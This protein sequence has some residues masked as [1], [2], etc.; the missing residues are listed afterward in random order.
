MC[1]RMLSI[2]TS[3]HDM[4]LWWQ[5][6]RDIVPPRDLIMGKEHLR[7]ALTAL[8]QL[9]QANLTARCHAEEVAQQQ[10]PP[11]DEQSVSRCQGLSADAAQQ[12]PRRALQSRSAEALHAAQQQGV[13]L[14][15][16]AHAHEDAWTPVS[17]SWRE[18]VEFMR[19]RHGCADGGGGSQRAIMHGP[20]TSSALEATLLQ[21]VGGMPAAPWPQRRA[22]HP[23]AAA[24]SLW[25]KTA[26][27]GQQS[28]GK[29]LAERVMHGHVRSREL[30]GLGAGSATGL[31]GAYWKLLSSQDQ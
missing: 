8:R 12:Q 22:S 15:P 28:P 9:L 3:S 27:T 23:P 21:R 18:L 5:V 1:S 17:P 29:R 10:P 13:E 26:Q 24:G 31:N 16:A 7:A 30:A 6:E 2:T 14:L 19:V 11:A 20:T 25:D 4:W